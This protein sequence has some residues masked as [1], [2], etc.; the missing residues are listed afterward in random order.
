MA[1]QFI[2]TLVSNNA[3]LVHCSSETA[4]VGS[5][6]TISLSPLEKLQKAIVGNPVISCSTIQ[7][8]DQMVCP[9]TNRILNFTGPIGIIVSPKISSSITQ[10]NHKDSGSTPLFR[11]ATRNKRQ[12]CEISDLQNSII[13]RCNYNEIFTH[14]YET[15]GVFIHRPVR[16]NLEYDFVDF[17]DKEIFR[18]YPGQDF[19]QLDNGEFIK[20]VF[21]NLS[22]TFLASKK[23]SVAD[24]YA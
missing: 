2:N 7:E 14:T 9:D 18:A 6:G 19:Y 20:L 1:A 16:F 23:V 3:V 5:A 13:H 17:T 12:V 21:D 15:I 11:D 10:A 24:L 22:N 8:G 4:L